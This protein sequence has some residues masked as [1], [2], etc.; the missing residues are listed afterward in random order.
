LV[1]NHLPIILKEKIIKGGKKMV[2]LVT[3]NWWP[4]GKS[5]QVGKRYLE[6]VKKYPDD[7]SISKPILRGAIWTTDEGM[8]SIT[9]ESVKPGKVKE[10]M[11]QATNQEL[12]MATI[13]GWKYNIHIAYDLA[14]AMPLIGLKAP[15]EAKAPEIY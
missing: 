4:S 7:R 10:A 3:E 11:D 15:E 12:M 13:E 6:A 14:E 1:Q 2:L 5:E 8:H 9:V